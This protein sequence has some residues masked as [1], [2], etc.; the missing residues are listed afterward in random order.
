MSERTVVETLLK[1]RAL[2]AE[3]KWCKGSYA[4]DR[5]GVECDVRGPSAVAWCALGAIWK[6]EPDLSRQ[7]DVEE[8]LKMVIPRAQR[9]FLGVPILNDA[10]ETTLADVLALYDRAIEMAERETA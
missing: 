7:V 6:F 10:P 5:D 9:I 8:Y 1:A 3:G 2:L 4:V